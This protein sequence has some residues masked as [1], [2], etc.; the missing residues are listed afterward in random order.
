MGYFTYLLGGSEQPPKHRVIDLALT[1]AWIV[2]ALLFYRK[3]NYF[4]CVFS[5]LM[6]L[7][8][9]YMA[10]PTATTNQPERG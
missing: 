5:G 3:S 10:R 7:A 6:A 4:L 1:V 9:L 2:L 8:R